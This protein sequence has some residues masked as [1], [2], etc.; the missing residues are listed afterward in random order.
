MV[1]GSPLI[2]D[3]G[4]GDACSYFLHQQDREYCH[5][6]AQMHHLNNG[7][8]VSLSYNISGQFGRRDST[9]LLVEGI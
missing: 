6:A 5:K 4:L 7:R 8:L 3:I 2:S 1:D 9:C